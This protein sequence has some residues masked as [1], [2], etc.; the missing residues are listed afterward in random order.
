MDQPFTKD[1]ALFR[2]TAPVM[3]SIDL[4][5]LLFFD[6]GGTDLGSCTD[7][8]SRLEDKDDILFCPVS[9]TA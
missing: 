4:P 2:K 6:D 8:L 7:L 1:H 9:V 5:D 3:E